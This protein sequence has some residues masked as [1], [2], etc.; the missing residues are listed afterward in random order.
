MLGPYDDAD[1]TKSAEEVAAA[2]TKQAG[3]ST[4]ELIVHESWTGAFVVLHGARKGRPAGF[5][6]RVG[7]LRFAT[8]EPQ[9][10]PEDEDE[11]GD[12]F[13]R[14]LEEAW[15]ESYVRVARLL[16][17]PKLAAALRQKKKENPRFGCL[18]TDSYGERREVV[19]VL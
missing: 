11:F 9:W 4:L 18:I 17:H 3:G 15:E 2:L 14:E 13:E 19:K 10:T 6:G 1:A 5:D 8:T 12:G 7:E 16:G